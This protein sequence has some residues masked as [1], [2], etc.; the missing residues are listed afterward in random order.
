MTNRKDKIS[1]SVTQKVWLA[2]AKAGSRRPAQDAAEELGLSRATVMR[3]IEGL[4]RPERQKIGHTDEHRPL[5]VKWQEPYPR[6]RACV[7]CHVEW[8]CD[9]AKR[10]GLG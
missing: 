9:A 2:K 4:P 7:L 3:H 8:P 6:W 5:S 1:P 10:A